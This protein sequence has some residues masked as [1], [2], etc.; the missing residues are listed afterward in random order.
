MSP[1]ELSPSARYNYTIRGEL[2]YRREIVINVHATLVEGMERPA[3]EFV[4]AHG[5]RY[6]SCQGKWP[7][8][9]RRA[10]PKAPTFGAMN[11]DKLTELAII[12]L[13]EH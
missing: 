5:L 4:S 10:S 7:L 6:P 1:K 3:G 8:P 13:E 11:A 2:H 12:T 9:A